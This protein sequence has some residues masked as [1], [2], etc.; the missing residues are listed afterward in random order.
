MRPFPLAVLL[1][2]IAFVPAHAADRWTPDGGACN[3]KSTTYDIA[4]CLDQRSKVWDKRLNDA[5]QALMKISSPVQR[6]ALKKAQLAWL[7]Y[8]DANCAYYETEAGT[9]RMIDV[10]SC[11]RDM[12]QSRAIE[13]QQDGPR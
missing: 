13:L 4:G 8:R 10:A 11:M 6:T 5:Y 7:R 1:A 9:I 2:G 12:T 3:Q